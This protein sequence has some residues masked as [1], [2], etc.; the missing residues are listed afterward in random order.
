MLKRKVKHDA[1]AFGLEQKPE[2]SLIDV[3][4]RI[5]SDTKPVYAHSIAGN[6]G[7]IFG[8]RPI[9]TACLNLA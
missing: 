8:N 3:G 9:G 1:F 4:W 6:I 2:V 5:F 7:H